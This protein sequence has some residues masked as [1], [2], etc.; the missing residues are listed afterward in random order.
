M[1]IFEAI[2]FPTK[3]K[4]SSIKVAL[5]ARYPLTIRAVLL[6]LLLGIM[7]SF[8]GIYL[9]L[10][11]GIMALGG[12]FLLGYLV[13]SA[14]GGYDAKENAIILTIVGACMLSAMGFMD[15]M[16]ALI[17]YK[18]Y[19]TAEVTMTFPFLVS[20]ILPGILLGVFVLYPFYKEFMKLRWPMVTPMAYMVKV[21]EKTGSKELRYAVK[22][23]A[24]SSV[25][26][27]SL[28]L[29]G[30][31]QI[32]FSGRKDKNTLNFTSIILSP[33]YGSIGFFI[34][35]ISYVFLI[36]GVGYSM[37]V[38]FFIE[39][40]NPS[41]NL[42][43]HFFN[44]YIYSVAIPMMITTAILT[45]IDYGKKLR[46]TIKSIATE[47]RLTQLT[48]IISLTLLPVTAYVLL[49]ITGA[50]ASSDLMDVIGIIVVALPIVFISS[51]F[52]VRA[53][54]ETG[55]SSSFTLDAT[56]ILTLLIFSPSFESILIAFAIIGVFESMAISLMRRIKFCS[57]IGVEPKNVIEA[58]MIGGII[59]AIFGPWIFLIIH[60]Y[61]GGIGSGLW[62]APMAKL[63]GGYVLLFYT[64]I[65]QRRLPPMIKPELLIISIFATICI[66]FVL[67]K[68][69]LRNL[70][71]ILIAIGMIIPPS[72][73]W[74]A[75]IGA[76]I[77]FRLHKKFKEKPEVYKEEK[78]KWN[79]IL[80]GVMS[81]E[82][83]V[84]FILTMLA[85]LPLIIGF[86]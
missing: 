40:A 24:F 36:I 67:R 85:I 61:Q 19:V 13:L 81:G 63:L 75:S 76:L 73:L 56:L 23:M 52:A 60:H 3:Q 59:G 34:S 27:I 5:L 15:A 26:S 53:S 74:I 11:I 12:I 47:S 58:V 8:I 38:W 25:T 7:I 28:M 54:G 16:V 42:Q 46:T 86:L 84:I 31:Y 64:A 83:I 45:L 2:K 6:G 72:F 65:K 80:A 71:P 50:L 22:G 1:V 35:F 51:I 78:S 41:I 57:I 70:S 82:G 39:G 44:P 29:S 55:F 68:I 30:C 69:G 4:R 66:W 33:L 43:Q 18:D 20:I 77:D 62:P 10:K 79:A 21:L 37:L 49:S 48:S 17:V 14:T 9:Y 32:D